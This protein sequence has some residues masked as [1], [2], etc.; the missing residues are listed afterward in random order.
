VKT[1]QSLTHGYESKFE[2]EDGARI[3][4][5]RGCGVRRRYD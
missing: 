1:I 2:D 3:L 4:R 5:W